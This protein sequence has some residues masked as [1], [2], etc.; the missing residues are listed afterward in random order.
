MRLQ[1]KWI[2]VLSR[3]TEIKSTIISKRNR[4]AGKITEQTGLRGK[5][6]IKLLSKEKIDRVLGHRY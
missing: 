1:S 4:L 6:K 2:R 3:K 5:V